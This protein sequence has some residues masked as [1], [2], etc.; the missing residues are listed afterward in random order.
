[1]TDIE[2]FHQMDLN[3]SVKEEIRK[4]GFTKPTAVQ[5]KV[6]PQ[7][8]QGKD[9]I[10]RSQT[11]SGKTAAY[12]IPIVH[13]IE[14]HKH[15]ISALI[16][17]PTRELALQVEA[18]GKMLVGKSGINIA[19]IYG[20]VS[21]GPQ[22][23]R[24]RHADIVIGTPGRLLDH[25]K[26][27]NLDVFKINYLVL[28][29]AD[30]MLDMGFFKDID[31][32]IEGTPREKQ[33]LLLSATMPREIKEISLKYMRGINMISEYDQGEVIVNT[34]KHAYTISSS[35]F[36][37]SVL[38]GYLD[39]KK[40]KK[41]I[42]F[43]NTR[44]T[45]F[46]LYK[47]IKDNNYKVMMLSGAMKQ[48]SRERSIKEFKHMD[49]GILITTDVASRGID[50]T[51]LTDII[52]FDAPKDPTV[53]TH[54]VGRTS[55]LG[56]EGAAFTI[57]GHEQRSLK[58]SVERFAKINMSKVEVNIDHFKNV[59]FGK[60]VSRDM[61][62]RPHRGGGGRD[63]GGFD[64]RGRHDNRNRGGSRPFNRSRGGGGHERFNSR[65]RHER[66]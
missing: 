38:L 31:K 15:H 54:R 23:D 16:M 24:L 26:R 37:F 32:I 29:E 14:K 44:N 20:G 25:L 41:T 11:A 3:Q 61:E 5:L 49:E 27:G 2:H 1:M 19:I 46:I 59:N 65:S 7:I 60:Y 33:T 30:I 58:E 64:N 10:V 8:L 9:V 43:A 34:I 22:L 40:P 21:Y 6:I 4:L 63:R 42:I 51:D 17:L 18:F 36:K 12:M 48:A 55:R 52:N 39:Q 57:F 28:D 62:E 56:A 35:S 45:A 50:I 53:Y 13:M 47:I 66:R